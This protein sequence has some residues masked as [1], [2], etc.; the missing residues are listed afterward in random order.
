MSDDCFFSPNGPNCEDT[1]TA[2]NLHMTDISHD[3]HDWDKEFKSAQQAFVSWAM[4]QAAQAAHDMTKFWILVDGVD[5]DGKA[6]EQ[7]F[8]YS[9]E[10]TLVNEGVF[11]FPTW[12]YGAWL[13]DAA[14]ISLL[15]LMAFTQAVNMTSGRLL[16]VNAKLWVYGGWLWAICTIISNL[17]WEYSFVFADVTLRGVAN[18]AEELASDKGV[19]STELIEKLTNDMQWSAIR[20]SAGLFLFLKYREAWIQ[21]QTKAL[22]A[23]GKKTEFLDQVGN[24]FD[25]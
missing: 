21:G 1:D 20:E 13:S 11:I 8:Y 12:R 15:G 7:V 19:A 5:V 14:T 18:D 9:A 6:E 17:L 24:I 22:K 16:V 25:F 4:L 2:S 10:Y 23:A 3:S